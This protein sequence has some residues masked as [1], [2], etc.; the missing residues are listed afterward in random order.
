MQ[1][2]AI[3]SEN[4][5]LRRNLQHV[6]QALGSYQRLV[7]YYPDVVCS[8]DQSGRVVHINAAAERVWGYKPDEL[9][10]RYY[11]DLVHPGDRH[12]TAL[13][14]AHPRTGDF[15]FTIE[16]RLMHKNGQVHFASWTVHWSG[17]DRMFYCTARDMTDPSN[18]TN[19][20]AESTQWFKSLFEHHPDGVFAFSLEGKLLSANAAFAKLTGYPDAELRSL[21]FHAF[22]APESIEMVKRYFAAA[23]RGEPSNFE[24]VGLRKDGSRYEASVTAV[25]ITVNGNI[26]GVHG[27]ARDITHTKNYE[28]N[29][30]RLA[31]H[32]TLTGLPNRTLLDD[33]IRHAI[34]QAERTGY[35]VGVLFI[36]LNRFKV[37]NDSLGHDQG[38][39]LLGIVAGRLKQC[40][41]EADTVARIGGDEFAVVLEDITSSEAVI[42]VAGS[43][44]AM[45]EKPVRLGDHELIVSASIGCSIYPKDGDNVRSLLRNADLAMYEAKSAGSGVLRLYKADMNE[46]AKA[47][48]MHEH[49]LRRALD[50]EELVVYYQPRVDVSSNTIVGAEAL[51]RWIHPERGLVPPNE[52]IPLAEEIGLID[53]LGE[54][55]LNAACVQNRA[56]QDAGLPALKISVN[57]SPLQLHPESTITDAV[58]QALHQT[59]LDAKWLELEIT[60]TSLMQNLESTLV[61]L[62]EIRNAG[63]SISIDDFGTGYSSLSHLRRLPVSGLKIDQSFI[64]EISA[65]RDDAA[66]VAATIALAHTMNLTVVAEGVTTE[67]QI[68]FLAA[69]DCDEVQG[70]LLGAAVPPEDLVKLLD[71][72]KVNRPRSL[73]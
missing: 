36:D 68:R 31:M 50:N 73:H 35:R 43:I 33:R 38:D 9:I 47:R 19:D 16:N 18:K 25:P 37:V 40:V 21:S 32:D 34:V 6:Q 10:G 66:I 14:P 48:L 60:E 70:F 51:V 71:L 42:A 57:L 46:R 39:V 61:K 22:V 65:S 56:W 63:V 26:V 15:S 45:I 53:Q 23:A 44:I 58:K 1:V 49:H 59:G 69:N 64:R 52:F 2:N 54:W 8:I 67:E 17:A 30:E 12:P 24:G 62:G 5:A 55:V 29:I 11:L 3:L 4:E 20:I 27:I 13:A 28:R 72:Q 7:N 41:R